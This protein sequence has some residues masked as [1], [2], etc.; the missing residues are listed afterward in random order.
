MDDP[1]MCGVISCG[2]TTL[3]QDV[4]EYIGPERREH[5][6]VPVTVP[7][8]V[9]PL[10]ARQ[11]EAAPPFNAITR[12]VSTGGLCYISSHRANYE[13]VA[14]WRENDPSRLVVCRVC[15]SNL[16][17]STDPE[18]AYLVSVEFLYEKLV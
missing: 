3:F 12:D 8:T 15:K 7:I 13:M 16:I 11:R 18:L 6:R 9:Q 14:I 1:F 17:Q 10:D 2:A 5:R 4:A